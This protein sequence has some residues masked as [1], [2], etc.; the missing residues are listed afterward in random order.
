ML[1]MPIPAYLSSTNAYPV[2]IQAVF[3]ELRKV[4]GEIPI[5]ASEQVCAFTSDPVPR[6]L[7]LLV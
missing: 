7:I 5:L 1:E 2:D 6:S 3:Q 4:L